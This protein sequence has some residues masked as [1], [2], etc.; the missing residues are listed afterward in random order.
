MRPLISQLEGWNIDGLNRA[1]EAARNNAETLYSSVNDSSRA[2][3]AAGD[4]KGQTRDAAMRRIDEEVD[5]GYEVRALLLRLADDADD[6]CKGMRHSRDYVLGQRDAAVGQGFVVTDDGQVTHPDPEKAGDAGVFQLNISSGLD[7]LERLD[8]TFGASLRDIQADLAAIRDEQQDITVPDGSRHDPDAVATQLASMSPDQRATFLAGMSP[9]A[10]R[11]LVIAAPE[12]LGN[13]NGVPFAMR[14]EA[15]EINIR[16]A[17]TVEKQKPDPDEARVRQLQAMLAPI[18]SPDTTQPGQKIESYGPNA[19]PGND[20][21]D[22]KFVMFDTGGNGHMIEM[23]G[24]M[25]PEAPGVGVYVPGT[26][27]NLNGSGSNHMAAWNLA[28]QT[29]GPIFLYMEGDFPQSL[30]SPSDGAPSPKFAQDMA[31][32]LV[33][34]GR[35]I[36]REVA[37]HAPGKPVSY[38]GHSYGG[39]IVA[40]AE[41]LG[42]R[43]DRILHASSAGTGVFEGSWNNPNPNVQ[44]YSMTAPGD[45]IGIVQSYP[46]AGLT[47]PGGIPI[48]GNPHAG[49]PLGGDPDEVPGVTRLDTGYYHSD[50]DKAGHKPEE[51]VFGPDGHGK[52]WDDPTSDAFKNIVGVIA[53]TDVTGYVERGIETPF[54]DVGLGDDGNGGKESFDAGKAATMG[55]MFG[56]DDPY[57]NPRVTDNPQPGPRIDVK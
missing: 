51:V 19:T 10:Q 55:Q 2:A 56:A 17:L 45:M 49:H 1:A 48:P 53:G 16:N 14:I 26:S 34:F 42:L 41:Q 20:L 12:K 21:I 52:Y 38:V 36:D 39:S 6:A 43:A 27:T 15:N 57:A 31:P 3:S 13:M 5:H 50:A 30:T 40:S 24:E 8:N 44:R 23:I 25:K 37:Q 29:G 32:K 4:W 46:Q 22:R 33:E 28:D 54:V 18:P 35:E 9:E 47:L 7:E 11:Q